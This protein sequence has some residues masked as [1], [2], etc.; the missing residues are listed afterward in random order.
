MKHK[1]RAVC[2]FKVSDNEKTSSNSDA[3]IKFC[4]YRLQFIHFPINDK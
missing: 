2:L 4:I 3:C 1:N